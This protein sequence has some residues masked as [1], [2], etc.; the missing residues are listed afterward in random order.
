[1]NNLA[2]PTHINITECPVT[3]RQIF[4][5]PLN[6]NKCLTHDGY[7]QIGIF[8]HSMQRHME[9]NPCIDW[10]EVYWFPD[11]FKDRYKR[12]KFQRTE[13][14]NEGSPKTDNQGMGTVDLT[15]RP[16]DFPDQAQQR[17]DRAI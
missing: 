5:V 6:E 13:A 3:T 15:S 12:V 14:C 1:M 8:N 7:I 10:Q 16:R 4:I 2:S 17:L 11:I 9:I